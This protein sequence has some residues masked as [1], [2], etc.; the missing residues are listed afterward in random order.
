[1]TTDS[2]NIDAA[3]YIP[4][5]GQTARPTTVYPSAF[6]P[7]PAYG[8]RLRGVM[9]IHFN[10]ASCLVVQLADDLPVTRTADLLRLHTAY[11]LR[12]VVEGFPHKAGGIWKSIHHFTRGFV[13]QVTY[14]AMR[15]CEHPGLAPLQTLP[16]PRAFRLGAL[17]LTTRRQLLVAI[18]HC[19]FRSTATYQNRLL[20]I[21]RC[22]QGIDSKVHANDGPLWPGSIR[23]FAHQSYCC[24]AD[25]DFHQPARE[26][27]RHGDTQRATGAMRQDE[28]VIA[29]PRILVCVD[30]IPVPQMFPRVARVLMAVLPQ[31]PCTIYRFAELSHNLLGALRAQPRISSLTPARPTALA[32]PLEVTPAKPMVPLNKI[33]PQTSGFLARRGERVPFRRCFRHP[34]YFYR[35]IAHTKSVRC[36]DE[37]GKSKAVALTAERSLHPQLNAGRSSW[38][39]TSEI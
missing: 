3:N 4:G 31:L 19:R 29:Y 8:T 18:L 22:N 25:T 14:P 36:T 21:S 26:H 28:L 6:I 27:D 34:M 37:K 10:R 9:F 13:R 38:S 33:T 30:D 1:M 16:L 35:P 39:T 5:C 23:D 2:Q 32:R 20:P 11:L 12:S 15:L 24:H 17:G 7:F